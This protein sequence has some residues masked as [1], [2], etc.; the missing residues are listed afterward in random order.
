VV[1]AEF[2]GRRQELVQRRSNLRIDAKHKRLASAPRQMDGADADDA[3]R[4]ESVQATIHDVFGLRPVM[5]QQ[6][7]DVIV[8]ARSLIW[9][10]SGSA[11]SSAISGQARTQTGGPKC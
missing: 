10:R 6:T 9:H 11:T 7:S 5:A 1:L 2:L 8:R 4:L 3:E